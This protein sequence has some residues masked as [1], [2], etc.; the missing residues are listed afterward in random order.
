MR[1][2]VPRLKFGPFSPPQE[3]LE[4]KFGGLPWG[5]PVSLWPVCSFCGKYQ[6]LI[7]QLAHNDE[8]LD[9]GKLGRVLHIFQCGEWEKKNCPTWE[10]GSGANAC[11][12][13]EPQELGERVTAPVPS[14]K[15]SVESRVATWVVKEDGIDPSQ[16]EAFFDEQSWLSLGEEVRAKAY[17]ATMLRGTPAWAQGPRFS[18]PP[19][20][21]ADWR[22]V[23]Q[24][25]DS[26]SFEGPPP[27]PNE[28]G[29]RVVR[30]V[31]VWDGGRFVRSEI[32]S[33]EEPRTRKDNAPEWVT[34]IAAENKWHY[35][36]AN[37]GMGCAYAFVRGVE[38]LFSWQR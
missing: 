12:V 14:T 29:C 35:S 33:V 1:F 22:F 17:M 2:F 10:P 7:A 15:T 6:S 13:V 32:A 3:R 19:G 5:L 28:I 8:R 16:Y 37:F 18:L 27:S 30:Q 11:F 9:L 25:N 21:L 24:I 36:V 31:N 4:D 38:G 26:L 34:Y 20:G 23:L